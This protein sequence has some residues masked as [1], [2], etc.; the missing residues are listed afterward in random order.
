MPRQSRIDKPGVLHHIIFIYHGAE[1]GNVPI[2]SHQSSTV[3][4]YYYGGVET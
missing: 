2:R 4:A 3:W 1:V